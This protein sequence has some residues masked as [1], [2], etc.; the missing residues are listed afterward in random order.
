M[1]WTVWVIIIERTLMLIQHFSVIKK[2]KF[3]GSLVFLTLILSAC[4]TP[5]GDAKDVKNKISMNSGR[6]LGLDQEQKSAAQANG[7]KSA[8][9]ALSS[10]AFA[11][12]RS[13]LDGAQVNELS[14]KVS[15]S[16]TQTAI[17]KTEDLINQKANEVVNSKGHGK[18]QVSLRQ[19]ETKNPQFS[20][21]TIQPLSDLTDTSTQLTF[22]Q[23]QISSG[24]NHGERRATINLG[25]GQR[26]LLEDGQAI[27]GVNLFTDYETES[28]HSRASLSLEYQRANFS[29]NANKYH[30]LSSKVV[31]GD[32]TEEPLAGY[33]IRLTGQMPYLPWARIKGTQYYWDA[34]TGEDIKGTHLGIEADINASTTLEVG[35]KNSN[36]AN[37]SAYATLRV[38]L[39]YSANPTSGRLKV[40]DKAFEDSGGISLTDLDY[41][42]RSNKIRVEKLLNGVSVVLGD[43]NAV[44]VGATCT[45]FNAAGIPIANGS[46]STGLD[47]LVSLSNVVLPSGLVYSECTSGAYTDEATG[48]SVV[49]P[50]IRAAIRYSG[51]GGVTMVATPLSE[52]AYQMAD[53]NAGTALASN[54][55][56]INAEVAT[57][58]GLGSI[59]ITSAI[60]TDINTAIVTNDGAGKFAT[61]LAAISQMGEN[62]GDD[63]PTDTMAALLADLQGS[64]GSAVG[65]IEGRNSGTE[66][67]DIATAIHNFVTN[68][69]DNNITNGTTSGNIISSAG[70]GRFRGDLAIAI[71]KAY[72]GTGTAPTLRHYTDVGVTGVTVD[73]ITA[74]NSAVA[75]KAVST[76]AQIQALVDAI[77]II[78]IS[79]QSRSIAENS[80]NGA[81]VGAVLV[82]TG[83]PT[84]FSIT[85]GNTNNAFAISNSGQITV[86]TTGE[87][88]YETTTSYALAVEITKADTTSQ[89]AVITI[90]VTNVNEGSV[91]GISA[92]MLEIDENSANG[93][94]VGA[95]LET[96]GGP[97]GFSITSGNTNDAFAISADGQIAVADSGELDFETTP[98]YTLTVEITKADTDSQSA[99]ITIDVT[100]FILFGTQKWSA[101][102]VSFVP[103]LNN[104]LDTDYRTDSSDGYLYTWDAAMN[105]CPSGWRLPSDDDWKVL[106][107]YIGLSLAHQDSSNSWRGT[108]EGAALKVGGSS[109]F[110]GPIGSWWS[111]TQ[112]LGGTKAYIRAL[113]TTDDK[114]GRI[115]HNF[116][117]QRSVRCLKN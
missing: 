28:K 100:N 17:N 46:G 112:N 88:D 110:E 11:N 15:S 87:L 81:N 20:I 76:T 16:L 27:A 40:A 105:V 107:G 68:S 102:N 95:V 35:T 18:T 54:I 19:L 113:R 51:T 25:I 108:N 117:T 101:S 55:A 43:F 29:A 13:A 53:T 69:G 93:A 37:R 96:T 50:K 92:Q 65:T 4:A 99:N 78:G 104:T 9:F 83:G 79:A 49:T 84:G 22:T 8:H 72:E 98:S 106:E 3:F 75:N 71:I 7:Q 5:A 47:G 60:P 77:K 91:I 38:Q 45:L 111:S 74:V 32:Y 66:V 39:P 34:V 12:V 89:N 48:D 73:D 33:D 2:V 23:A 36:T 44:T 56:A 67:V 90:T 82:T 52:I 42:E 64:D 63:N 70:E 80:A 58:F 86:A 114:I 26:Y 10:S 30:P 21:K 31:I 94:N 6:E 41:V 115:L 85:S 109:G 14:D 62:S 61:I 57:A 1:S 116:T 59:N 97:T 24:E 103:T